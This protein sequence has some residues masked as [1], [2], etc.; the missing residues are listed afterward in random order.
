MI[1]HDFLSS[2]LHQ[3]SK[4][5]KDNYGKVSSTVKVHDPNQVLT[6]TDLA[7][8]KHVIDVITKTYPQHNIVDEEAGVIDKGSEYTWFVDPID[9][10]SNFANTVPTYATMIGLLKGIT[11]IAG[12][13]ALPAF[14][15]IIIAEKGHGAF[16]NSTRIHVSK[17]INLLE[18][19]IAY[20]VDSHKENRALTEEDMKLVTE[21]VLRIQNLRS[22]HSAFDGVMV[23]RGSYGGWLNKSC[24]IWDNVSLQIVIEEAGGIYTDFLGNSIDY[25]NSLAKG[26]VNYTICAAS[27]TLHAQLQNIVHALPQ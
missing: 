22:S 10:T 6:E 20:G 27:K 18:C 5:A 7:I 16:L 12:G 8:G 25:T 26:S 19:L 2:V 11:P 4:I 23:A 9:G 13:I 14:N 24:R 21:L 1:Y 3:T 15:E 17:K